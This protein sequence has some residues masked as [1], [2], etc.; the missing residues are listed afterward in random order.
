MAAMHTG[1]KCKFLS[2][3]S[4]LAASVTGIALVIEP[5]EKL[6]SLIYPTAGSAWPQT[7]QKSR[8]SPLL[9]RGIQKKQHTRTMATDTP[10]ENPKTVTSMLVS[11]KYPVQTAS[12]AP[13]LIS[14]A[15]TVLADLKHRPAR[16]RIETTT[17]VFA[18]D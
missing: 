6:L 17:S 5:D 4:G 14:F 8:S 12:S 10:Q 2:I 1:L 3:L 11:S 15:D 7:E 9:L 18:S 16:G 13:M